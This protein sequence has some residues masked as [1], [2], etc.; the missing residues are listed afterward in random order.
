MPEGR[1]K[2][3]ELSAIAAAIRQKNGLSTTYKPGE[4][5]AAIA[6]IPTGTTP[7]G[8]V[9]ITQNGTTDVTQYANANVNVPNSYSQA[10]EGKVVSNGALVAQTTR[11]AEITQNGTYDTTLNDEVTVNVSGGGSQGTYYESQ[12]G[13][14]GLL[15]NDAQCKWFF[16]GVVLPS[17]NGI[18][19]TDENLAPHVPAGKA[20]YTK[21][22][23][24][25][26]SSDKTTYIGDLCF[27][28]GVLKA[29]SLNHASWLSGTFWA[30]M[31]TIDDNALGTLGGTENIVQQR[32]YEEPPTT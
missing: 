9:S 27:E 12:D 25:A 28:Y 21:Y 19:I 16:N 30:T 1:I 2:D 20:L 23:T 6:A 32:T 4:M 7:T 8:T 5:A 11:S 22:C 14:I 18:T 3:S 13:T 29:L 31:V 10:D 24:K 17:T 26:Y 15:V